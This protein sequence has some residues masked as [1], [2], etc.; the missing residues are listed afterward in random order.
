M[1]KSYISP[2]IEEI[3]YDE[4]D[5]LQTSGETN[6]FDPNPQN[7]DNKTIPGSILDEIEGEAF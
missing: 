1:K 2:D 5:L 6:G 7:G 4:S 3:R